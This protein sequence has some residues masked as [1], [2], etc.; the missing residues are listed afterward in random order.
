MDFCSLIDD[1]CPYPTGQRY[2]LLCDILN[3]LDEEKAVL[4]AMLEERT[5]DGL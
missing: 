2:C 4:R 3:V 5:E 1:F